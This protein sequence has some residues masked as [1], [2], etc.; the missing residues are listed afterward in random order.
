VPF[1]NIGHV[2]VATGSIVGVVPPS[3]D[4]VPPEPLDP[5]EPEDPPPDPEPPGDPLELPFGPEALPEL[6]ELVA[7]P[8]SGP[9]PLEP[10]PPS[11]AGEDADDPLHPAA[12]TMPTTPRRRGLRMARGVCLRLAG[13]DNRCKR[14]RRSN[15]SMCPVDT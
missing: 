13:A 2:P 3:L 8:P 10:V 1:A 15:D 5:P 11:G 9:A 4:P 6:L 7:L 12:R 14:R